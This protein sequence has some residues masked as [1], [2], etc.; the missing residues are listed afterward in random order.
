MSRVQSDV[1]ELGDFLDS[2]A[3]WVAGEVVSL[4]AIMV[5]MITMQWKLALLTLVVVP[6]LFLF[7]ILWQKRARRTFSQVRQAMAV[8]NSSLE[9]AISGVRVIQSL[10][11]EDINSQ[12]FDRVN[13]AH[14]QATIRSTIV[15]SIMMPAVE[16]LVSIATALA[17]MYGG[18]GVLNGTILVGVLLAFIL[19]IQRF[20]DPIR[21]LTME[22]GQ[23]QRAM[24]SGARVFELLDVKPEV[25]EGAKTITPSRLKGEIRFE[26][27]S[28]RYEFG[29]EVLRGIDLHIPPGQTVALV[30]PTG[31]GKTTILSLIARFYDVT[32]GR[33]L[34]DGFDLNQLDVLAY[35]R[36]IGLV[37]QDPFLFSGTVRDN[38]GYGN[39]RATDAEIE[40]AARAV[41]AHEFITRLEK[42]YA[43]ELQERGQNLSMGQ[44]QLLS[45]AR[46]LLANPAILLLD[47]ATASLDSHSEHLLQESLLH[48]R[49]GR[50]TV[51][52]AHRLSTIRE[53][54]KIVVLDKG[55]IVEEGPH[56]QLLVQGGL[57]ARLYNLTYS[58]PAVQPSGHK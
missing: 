6:F 2:G 54:N 33:I 24:A 34:V 44:R 45:F 22:Y 29:S 16:L 17:I 32:G 58:A 3:F 15:S 14:F 35:R 49:Q 26:N 10:S 52:I 40:A 9:E 4:I 30:G 20:F 7:I 13:K 57:Y 28:F 25:A 8:V 47:E 18:L 23:L 36:Q 11:R 1:G 38:I 12:H 41:G 46:A 42:G 37:L 50:T 19:Y 39:L 53:A 43:T 27:V 48:L 5:V 31:A 21:T 51:I 55:R 56:E